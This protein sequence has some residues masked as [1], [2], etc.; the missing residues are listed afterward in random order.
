MTVSNS[1]PTVNKWSSAGPSQSAGRRS[2]FFRAVYLFLG[3]QN[4]VAGCHPVF[5]ARYGA[6]ANYSQVI[7]A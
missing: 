3:L 4:E 1:I 7:G 2:C 6:S 5:G